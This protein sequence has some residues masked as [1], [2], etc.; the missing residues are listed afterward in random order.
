MEVRKLSSEGRRPCKGKCNVR[1]SFF[2]TTPETSLT[3]LSCLKA[4]G[5][6]LK[7]P[8]PLP[9]VPQHGKIPSAPV[10]K[11]NKLQ[12]KNSEKEERTC[13]TVCVSL[14]SLLITVCFV[15]AIWFQAPGNSGCSAHRKVLCHSALGWWR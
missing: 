11:L 6:V 9:S 3:W 5:A 8:S 1:K 14:C 15:G 12:N 10:T 13:I 2:L 4:P 7:P